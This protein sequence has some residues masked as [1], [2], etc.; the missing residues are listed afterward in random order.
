[1]R[2]V[3]ATIPFSPAQ[4]LLIGAVA[5]FMAFTFKPLVIADGGGYFSYLHS[6]VFDH[7]L[8]MTD[9]YRAALAEHVHMAGDIH[10]RTITGVPPNQFAIGPAILS[11]PAYLLAALLRPSGTPQFSP[12]FSTAFT[13]AS[14]FYGLVAL[15]LVYRLLRRLEFSPDASAIAVAAIAVATPLLYYLVY[16]PSYSHTFSAFAVTLFVYVWWTRRDNRTLR[17]W[18]V[19][20]F[21]GGLMALVRW[22]DGPLM[23]I[24]LLDLPRARWRLLLLAPGAL[25]AFSPQLV[26]DEVIFGHLT[27][28]SPGVSFQ[29]FPGHYLDVLFSSL[30]GLFTWSPVL[31]AAV[32]GYRFVRNNTLRAAF[33]ICFLMQLAIVG[34]FLYWYGGFAFGMRFFINLTPF[35]AIGLAAVAIRIRPV[36]ARI[37]IAVLAAWNF[38]LI[39]SFTYTIKEDVA[40]GY[41]G[42]VQIQ[43]HS[44]TL[45]PHLI[46]GYVVRGL[47]NALLHRGGDVPGAIAVFLVEIV[48]IAFAVWLAAGAER[49]AQPA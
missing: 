17:G 23:A 5:I 22:Q 29:P 27:P 14:L 43:L 16:S 21:L 33:A 41:L 42:L 9:E 8:D 4:L 48:I 11:L 32:A 40:P 49:H 37:A 39:L 20:G 10:S 1:V 36:V 24:A 47:G 6:I 18:L 35:F 26:V 38:V 7:N 3:L 12:P 25:L 28:G 34:A 46:Q 19:L 44:L 31:L 15:A 30:H 45:L 13:L 2:R